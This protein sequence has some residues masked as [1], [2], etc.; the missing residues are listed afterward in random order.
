MDVLSETPAFVL[1]A[2]IEDVSLGAFAEGLG[3]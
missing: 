1:S 3:A 2:P